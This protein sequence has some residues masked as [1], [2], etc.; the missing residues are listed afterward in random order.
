V[1]RCDSYLKWSS[2]Q[3]C[4]CMPASFF[5][6]CTSLI[7]WRF[8]RS[9]SIWRYF[10]RLGIRRQEA[11]WSSSSG[12]FRFAKILRS[13]RSAGLGIRHI[14][15]KS[16]HI[17][18]NSGIFRHCIRW[19]RFSPLF[20]TTKSTLAR[21][22][23]KISRGAFGIVSSVR[24][25][26]KICVHRTPTIL[27][28]IVVVRLPVLQPI[29]GSI[30]LWNSRREREKREKSERYVLR[31]VTTFTALGRYIHLSGFG[32]RKLWERVVRSEEVRLSRDWIS[33]Q[34]GIWSGFHAK[35]PDRRCRFF[36]FHINLLTVCFSD[37]LFIRD[38]PSKNIPHT[39][40]QK[41]F[42]TKTTLQTP[43]HR[44]RPPRSH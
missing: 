29:S 27:I 12:S 6:V 15:E 13:N 14:F 25:I 28:A 2:S 26:G 41:T 34:Y 21:A 40:A 30:H 36:T 10:F 7:C 20:S 16:F 33:S 37:D 44:E 42:T 5:R 1:R 18:N 39:R 38:L 32:P 23:L 3:Y 31:Y 17:S 35:F 8:F 19:I 24:F 11:E 22:D 4:T 43:P 9:F